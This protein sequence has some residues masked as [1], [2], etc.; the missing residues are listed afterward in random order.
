MASLDL[1]ESMGGGPC[2][3]PMWDV[4][5]RTAGHRIGEKWAM[6]GKR[7]DGRRQVAL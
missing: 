1:A 5:R 7:P 3:G 6:T 4:I 2:P